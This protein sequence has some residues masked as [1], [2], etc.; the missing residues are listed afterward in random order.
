M[1]YPMADGWE[2]NLE[3]V[4]GEV[5]ALKQRLRTAWKVSKA[6]FLVALPVFWSAAYQV[7]HKYTNIYTEL[8]RAITPIFPRTLAYSFL[9]LTHVVPV[10][11][12][13]LA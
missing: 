12:W 5:N 3:V 11:A 7:L 1:T 13:I 4:D 2:K 8:F 6:E 10:I 9:L